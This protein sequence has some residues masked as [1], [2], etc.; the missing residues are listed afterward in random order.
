MHTNLFT[1][2]M[3]R[4][5]T[6]EPQ[7]WAEAFTRWSRDTEYI[8]LLDDAPAQAWSIT[9]RKQWLEKELDD[10]ERSYTFG[11][12]TL[13]DDQLIGFV[14]L[15]GI[16]HTHGDT[17]VGIGIGDR[18]YWGKGYGSEAMRLILRYAFS[19]LNLHR[20]SLGVFAYNT[21]AQRAYE[22][23]GFQ[24]EGVIHQAFLREGQRW[25][26][27]FMGILRAEWLAQNGQGLE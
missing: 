8:R 1:D 9:K 11:I 25:D 10:P 26:L 21:R 2:Q 16:Q 14:G 12:R 22:K 17:W 19:E 7:V 20:V 3:V 18:K 27:L 4:L 24:L 6:E 13:A 23:C 5:S 15:G